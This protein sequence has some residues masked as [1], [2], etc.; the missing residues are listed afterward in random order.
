[1]TCWQRSYSLLPKLTEDASTIAKIET[2]PI[3]EGRQ[4]VMILAPR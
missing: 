4:I 3:S 1:M 2:E